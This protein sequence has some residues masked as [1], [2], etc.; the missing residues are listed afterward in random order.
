MSDD[1]IKIDLPERLDSSVAR[2]LYTQI[3]EHAG[4]SIRFNGAE[5]SHIGGLC[6]QVLIAAKDEWSR[7]SLSLDIQSSSETLQS[8]LTMIDRDDLILSEAS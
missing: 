7:Q 8:F 1:C 6:L 2:D 4:A 5:V 3:N